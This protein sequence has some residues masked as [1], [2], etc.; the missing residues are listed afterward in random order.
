MLDFIKKIYC[1]GFLRKVSN[2][3]QSYLSNK[4][5][6]VKNSNK[7]LQEAKKININSK[8]PLVGRVGLDPSSRS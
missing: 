1:E 3:I 2:R 5:N 6:S 7:K 8:R 4:H